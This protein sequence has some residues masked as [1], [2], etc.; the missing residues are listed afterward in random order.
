MEL[1]SQIAKKEQW[2]FPAAKEKTL[3]RI[4]LIPRFCYS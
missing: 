1:C 2:T 3:E 4:A